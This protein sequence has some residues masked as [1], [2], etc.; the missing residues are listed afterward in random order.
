LLFGRANPGGKLP[1]TVPRHVGQVPVY[2]G[3]K[4]SGGRSHWKA[5]YVD[6]SNE[7]LWPFG[8]GLSYT[9]FRVDSLRLDRAS[10]PVD[11]EFEVRVDVTNTGSREGDEVVQLYLRD[12]E[13]SVTRPIK[14]LRGFKRVTLAP[15]QRRSVIFRVAAEQLAFTGVDGRRIVEPGRITVMAGTSA[16]DLPCRATLVVTGE[17]RVADRLSRFF[18]ETRVV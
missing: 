4:P 11:G 8:F 5:R 16:E 18:T 3:H 7:P 13:A 15:G 14:Q 12:D 2:Y 17:P 9:T 1:I 10:I 6:G